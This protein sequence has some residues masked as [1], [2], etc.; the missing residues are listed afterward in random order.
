VSW[1]AAAQHAA[2]GAYLRRV[3]AARAATIEVPV[4]ESALVGLWH[5]SMLA[6]MAATLGRDGVGVF[7]LDHPGVE[8]S[9]EL[10]ERLGFH[11][12]VAEPGSA[13]GVREAR[14]W[15]SDPGRLLAITLD[16]PAG[17]ARVAKPGA[18]R[19]ARMLN[20]PLYPL[21]VTASHGF[22]LDRWDSCLVPYPGAAVSVRALS[23][24]P[25]QAVSDHAA[26]MVQ[27]SLLAAGAAAVDGASVRHRAIKQW[28]RACTLPL[29]VG[30]LTI[31]P[32]PGNQGEHAGARG[33]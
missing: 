9:L 1:L 10:L 21:A 26:F 18:L 15:L 5:G 22:E 17:P 14:A 11:V 6:L 13:D 8:D 31:G 12:I 30:T 23:P 2:L 19:L 27:N 24:A 33:A 20:V 32:D 28:V 16:G 7:V 29:T 4:T 3:C 25:R